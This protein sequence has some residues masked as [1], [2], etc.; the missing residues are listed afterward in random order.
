MP[1][2]KKLAVGNQE[3]L[4][5]ANKGIDIHGSHYHLVGGDLRKFDELETKL[6]NECR[7]DFNLPT[8]ILTECVLVYLPPEKTTHLLSWVGSK[9]RTSFCV[10]YEQVNLHTR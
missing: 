5:V 10:N 7:L 3:S 1:A 4:T 9:F 8:L 6:I 2:L